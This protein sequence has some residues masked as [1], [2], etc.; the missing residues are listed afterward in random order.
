M[1]FT[2]EQLE[3]FVAVVEKGSFSSAARQL[4]KDRATVHQHVGNLEIDLGVTLF[5][6]S[7]KLPTPTQEAN[8]L[9]VQAKHIIYQSQLFESQSDSI[10]NQEEVEITICYDNSISPAVL[11]KINALTSEQYPFT[12][13]NWLHRGREASLQAI[14]NRD[15]DLAIT[16]NKGNNKPNSGIHFVNLGY[17]KFALYCHQSSPLAKTQSVE[18]ET[19]IKHKQYLLED[20]G[21]I[22]FGD[23][24][25]FS[26]DIATISN[27]DLL[28]E[29]LKH[30]G[31][32]ALSCDMM[33]RHAD[34][35]SYHKLN[36][37]FASQ[38]GRIGY[39]LFSQAKAA[40]GVVIQF[41]EKKII[42][43]FK[44]E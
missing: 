8:D 11:A 39:V 13:L 10:A 34:A 6:R 3:A 28:L 32:T 12:K 9:F 36:L 33:S 18:L 14:E 41:I 26:S 4:R 15:C 31:W 30:G 40:K 21:E 35:N 2:L 20:L 42:A 22:P 5:D 16:F 25:R 37:S 27:V 7:K 38:E 43:A 19:L 24:L 17:H 1:R 23:Q 29:T 44:S